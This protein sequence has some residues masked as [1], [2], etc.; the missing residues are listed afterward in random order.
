MVQSMSRRAA[1]HATMVI[2]AL[3][4]MILMAG[5]VPVT[6]AG[7]GGETVSLES[8]RR[9][10]RAVLS[11][12]ATSTAPSFSIRKQTLYYYLGD[13]VLP[14]RLPVGDLS[15]RPITRADPLRIPLRDQGRIDL[16]REAVRGSSDVEFAWLAPGLDQ[17][18]RVVA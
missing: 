18:E 3:A 6:S 4:A 12:P 17:A 14:D 2:G 8:I 11:M 5:A 16:L 15:D 1:R 13:L 10:A 9:L 7:R